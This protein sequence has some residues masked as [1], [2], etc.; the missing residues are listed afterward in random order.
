MIT[1]M[2][3]VKK[4][5]E[6]N[7]PIVIAVNALNDE[8][9]FDYLFLISSVRYDYAKEMYP[10]I[11]FKIKKILLSCIKTEVSNDEM[12]LNF[13][14]VVKY[15]WEHFDNA[16]L[17]SLRLLDNLHVKNVA[18]AGFDEF[19]NEYN[20]SYAD[21]ALP[22]VNPDNGWKKLNEEI[23]DMFMDFRSK[24]KHIENLQFITKSYFD[25]K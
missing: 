14:R 7:N 3:K 9:T 13:N 10:E 15:G 19:K 11:F 16:G 8:Y 4:Y 17:D 12:I 20:E 23:L 2:E 1:E 5:I 24:M 21:E 25:V 6:E 22:T 18:I